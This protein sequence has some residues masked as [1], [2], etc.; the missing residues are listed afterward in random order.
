MKATLLRFCELSWGQRVEIKNRLK[1]SK[2]FSNFDVQE[3]NNPLLK[4]ATCS[5]G[6]GNTL[7]FCPV[8]TCFLINAFPVSPEAS[9]EAAIAAGDL[10]D[11]ELAFQ[12]SRAGVS[13]MLI[14]VPDDHPALRDKEKFGDFKTV[15]VYQR[16][17]P[18]TVNSGGMRLHNPNSLPATNH[19]N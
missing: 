13:S 16:D 1:K 19:I 6:N 18:L 14:M 5:D 15:R 10:L 7:V 9:P 12:A 8:Q 3:F 17:F 11:S 2:S 4:V